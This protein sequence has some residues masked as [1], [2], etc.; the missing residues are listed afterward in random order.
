MRND[1]RAILF[2]ILLVATLYHC[3]FTGYNGRG[4]QDNSPGALLP[5]NDRHLW[6]KLVAER[7]PAQ[8]S[9]GLTITYPYDGAVFP[10][11]MAA[12]TFQWTDRST[13]STQWLV[14]FRFGDT[15][16]PLC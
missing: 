10:P 3:T 12:P 9:T 5:P 14:V 6:Q 16:N 1:K 2:F 8:T 13:T 11:E 15:Q 7:E 4:E